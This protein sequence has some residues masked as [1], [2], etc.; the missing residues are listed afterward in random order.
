MGGWGL[1][2]PPGDQSAKRKPAGE[3][4]HIL[5]AGEPKVCSEVVSLMEDR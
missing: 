3:K 5:A 4:I 2:I 1:L